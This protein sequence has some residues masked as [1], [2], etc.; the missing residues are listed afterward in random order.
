MTQ[1]PPPAPRPAPYQA[2][3]VPPT[4]GRGALVMAILTAAGGIVQL[5]FGLLAFQVLDFPVF[6]FGIIN[7]GSVLA[8]TL[9]AVATLAVG[10]STARRGAHLNGGIAIGAG[11]VAAVSCVASLLFPPLIGMLSF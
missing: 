3:V 1:P 4:T 2:A 6:T 5:L 9:L 10:V 11:G 8:L 7:A